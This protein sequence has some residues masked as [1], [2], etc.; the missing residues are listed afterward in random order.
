MKDTGWKKSHRGGW[1]G[2]AGV[3]DRSLA[4]S[5]WVEA[6]HQPSHSFR[7]RD[8]VSPEAR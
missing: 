4:K 1:E 7:S 3:Q 2:S 8:P 5:D 6:G